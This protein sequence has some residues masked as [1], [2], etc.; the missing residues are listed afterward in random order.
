M[1]IMMDRIKLLA[2]VCFCLIFFSARPG[3]TVLVKN[4]WD[5]AKYH[6]K[7]DE[8]GKSFDNY[9][10]GNLFNLYGLPASSFRTDDW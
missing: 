3:T 1:M 8:E 6:V 10:D 7:S 4:S 9:V 2:L 5:K